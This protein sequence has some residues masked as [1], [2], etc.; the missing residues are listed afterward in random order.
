V[1]LVQAESFCDI[2]EQ[3]RGEQAKALANFLPNWDR[4]KAQGRAL[5]TPKNAYGAYTMRTEF[6]MLTG[7]QMPDLGAFAFN[8]YLLAARQPLWSLARFF[9]SKG[10]TTVCV[11]PYA[12]NF[13]ARDAVMHNLGFQHFLG[14][15][16]LH[17]LERFG[18]YT[19]DIALGNFLQNLVAQSAS[20]ILTFVITIES[21]G[22]WHTGRL[23]NAQKAQCLYDIDATL[24]D[25]SLSLYLCHLRHMDNLFGML[26]GE[27]AEHSRQNG[28]SMKCSRDRVVLAYGDHAPGGLKG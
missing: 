23:S 4:L 12:K 14:L 9:R 18:P 21:H 28:Q 1:V 7:L 8:P 24:F 17:D 15:E 19:S 26:M 11:H 3:V 25:E 27:D 13:F 5:P 16:D 20:P 22:P 10:Y 6:S 2:R